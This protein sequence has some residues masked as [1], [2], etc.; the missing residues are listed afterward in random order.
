MDLVS[1][2]L[3]FAEVLNPV[4]RAVGFY[5]LRVL[6]WGAYPRVN[7]TD[8]EDVFCILLGWTEIVG[9]LIVVGLR[10]YPHS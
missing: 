6:S 1:L 7:R 3:D 4:A 2:V 5:T 8:S 10:L 9:V